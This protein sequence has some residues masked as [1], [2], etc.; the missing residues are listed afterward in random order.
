MTMRTCLLSLALAFVPLVARAS[1]VVAL[2]EP[3]LIAVADTIVFGEVLHTRAVVK[4]PR[5]AVATEVVLQVYQGLRGARD[6]EVLTLEV[7][8]GRLSSGLVANSA[9]APTFT[10]GEMVFV[11]LTTAGGVRRPYGLAY[12]VL[13]A[14]PDRGSWVLRRDA[15]D[16]IYWDQSGAPV[17]AALTRLEDVPLAVLA[18]RVRRRLLELSLPGAHEVRP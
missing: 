7:P 9:G 8:G 5:G 6:G 2:L 17:D 13:R 3:E 11:F 4:A 14:R 12:G 18:D 15:S 10:P 1:I 16:L